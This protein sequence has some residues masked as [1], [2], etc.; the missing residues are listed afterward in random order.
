ML[1]RYQARVLTR[2][3]SLLAIRIIHLVLQSPLELSTDGGAFEGVVIA[4]HDPKR[5]VAVFHS[6]AMRVDVDAG[7][8]ARR[9]G[10]PPLE[11]TNIGCDVFAIRA[12]VVGKV[13]ARTM[14]GVSAE[15][16]K[17]DLD[18]ANLTTIV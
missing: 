11:G 15:P 16:V 1:T 10:I 13:M 9:I 14:G 17:F 5:T 12:R 6:F 18:T 2:T 4:V 7:V 8:G 3:H